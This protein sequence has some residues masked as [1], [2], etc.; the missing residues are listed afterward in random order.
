MKKNFIQLKIIGK[1]PWTTHDIKLT[2]GEVLSDLLTKG[3]KNKCE[4]VNA[5]NFKQIVYNGPKTIFQSFIH[6]SL[7][8]EIY[9]RLVNHTKKVEKR[10]SDIQ[11]LCR[12]GVRMDDDDRYV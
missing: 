10:F 5:K 2:A 7:N 8:G 9:M 3:V 4:D 11:K 6:A 12:K 1:I